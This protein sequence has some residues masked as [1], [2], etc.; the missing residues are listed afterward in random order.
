MNSLISFTDKLSHH[1][2]RIIRDPSTWQATTFQPKVVKT[3]SPRAKTFEKYTMPINQKNETPDER[4][5]L[6]FDT[7]LH[8]LTTHPPARPKTVPNTDVKTPSSRAAPASIVSSVDEEPN[9]AFKKQQQQP[10]R[11]ERLSLQK[12]FS[13]SSIVSTLPKNAALKLRLQLSELRRPTSGNVATKNNKPP[14]PYYEVFVTTTKGREKYPTSSNYKSYPLWGQREGEWEESIID[15]GK[16]RYEITDLQIG[17][18]VM[19]CSK[20]GS[21]EKFIGLCR[22]PL[23]NLQLQQQPDQGYPILKGFEVMGWLRVKSFKIE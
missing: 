11:V 13:A 18:R 8:D 6:D 19:H 22:A 4:L 20:K 14:N 21:E 15:L 16:P 1:F 23:K 12:I 3:P 17:I 7:L 9:T 10:E 2:H 5:S